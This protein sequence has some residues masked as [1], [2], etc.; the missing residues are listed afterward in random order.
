MDQPV[1]HAAGT[2]TASTGTVD[3]A[4]FEI[5]VAVVPGACL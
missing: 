4:G 3:E 2:G 5:P 1:R